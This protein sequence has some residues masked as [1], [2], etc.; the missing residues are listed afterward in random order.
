M[1]IKAQEIIRED[2]ETLLGKHREEIKTGKK[3]ISGDERVRLNK[4]LDEKYSIGEKAEGY[5]CPNC[6]INDLTRTLPN[7]YVCT[8]SS[9]GCGFYF[10]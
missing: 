10:K 4:L 1:S 5:M 7:G 8:H 6:K 3:I 9:G 2:L